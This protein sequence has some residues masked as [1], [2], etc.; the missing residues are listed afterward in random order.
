MSCIFFSLDIRPGL[1]GGYHYLEELAR[2]ISG[3]GHVALL[4][5]EDSIVDV[6]M[7]E[8]AA[9]LGSVVLGEEHRTAAADYGG[10]EALK[11]DLDIGSALIKGQGVCPEHQF[12]IAAIEH[13]QKLCPGHRALGDGEVESLPGPGSQFQFPILRSEQAQHNDGILAIGVIAVD[14]TDADGVLVLQEHLGD[15]GVVGF[16]V[17]AD[18]IGGSLTALSNLEVLL[19]LHLK[20]RRATVLL[21]GSGHIDLAK[22]HRKITGLLGHQDDIVFGSPEVV[23]NDCEHSYSDSKFA[24]TAVSFAVALK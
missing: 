2:C 16:A 5:S 18:N 11:G 15:G 17:S 24:Q 19:H 21:S 9:G 4:N 22:H 20:E 10:K 14:G 12:H 1:S 7:V 8:L 6:R 13:G 23:A 3:L